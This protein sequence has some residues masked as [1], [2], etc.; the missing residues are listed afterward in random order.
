MLKE[1]SDFQI[2]S[3]ATRIQIYTECN[4][5]AYH[6]RSPMGIFSREYFPG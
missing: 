4:Y 5:K 3:T 1:V 6:S 2:N